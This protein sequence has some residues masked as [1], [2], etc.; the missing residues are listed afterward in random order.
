MY[1]TLL[2]TISC[3]WLQFATTSWFFR[4]TFFLDDES[5]PTGANKPFHTL[6]DFVVVGGSATYQTVAIICWILCAVSMVIAGYSYAVSTSKNDRF[7]N[8]SS[9]IRVALI[10]AFLSGVTGFVSLVF[11][12]FA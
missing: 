2:N 8:K 9:V 10:A 6:Y 12:I 3:T 5:D 7:M 4:N 11:K 1:N